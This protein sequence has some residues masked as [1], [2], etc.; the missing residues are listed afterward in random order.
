LTALLELRGEVL[1]PP[2][3]RSLA[4]LSAR[5]SHPVLLSTALARLDLPQLQVAEALAALGAGAGRAALYRMV[6]AGG[7]GER[8]AVDE[9]LAVLG[10][11]AMMV[12][13]ECRLDPGLEAGWPEPLDLGVHLADVLA[14]LTVDDLRAALSLW[15][16]GGLA[17]LGKAALV[18][19][20]GRPLGD[21]DR[22]RA[23]VAAAP[24]PLPEA[25]VDAA[26]GR[27]RFSHWTSFRPGHLRYRSS[28]LTPTEW[29]MARLLLVPS[30]YDGELQLPA[31][32]ALALR[33]PN[34]HAP[35]T[36]DPPAIRR[37][38]VDPAAVQRSA[39]A[40]GGDAVR[41]A[42]DVLRLVARQPP[43]LLKN[44]RLGARE[45]R[46]LGKELDTSP[47]RVRFV[48]A[49][50]HHRGLI[51]H[52]RGKLVTTAAAGAWLD[53]EPGA[54]LAALVA[55]WME[56]PDIPLDVDELAWDPVDL[57]RAVEARRAVL[58]VLDENPDLTPSQREDVVAAAYWRRP[59]PMGR[60][61]RGNVAP[62]VDDEGAE[63]VTDSDR[64]VRAL[65]AEAEILG[66]TGGGA[67][68]PAGRAAARGQDVRAAI[69][70]ALGRAQEHAVLQADLTA[71]V[72]GQPSAPLA[73]L[74]DLMADRESRSTANVWRFSPTSIRRALDTGR[75]ADDLIAD[76]VVA[77]RDEIPQALR[78]LVSDTG[79]QHGRLQVGG[80]GSYVV[81]EDAALLAEVVAD[82]RLRRLDLRLL[83][84]TVLVSPVPLDELMRGLRAAGHGAVALRPDGTPVIA[85]AG[86]GGSTPTAER[87]RSRPAAGIGLTGPPS[88]PRP[89]AV[90]TA[91]LAAGDTGKRLLD[92]G[93]TVIDIDSLREYAD[94]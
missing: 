70:S 78:Y 25:L 10:T 53:A 2:A 68:S 56:L 3:P 79:R 85:R 42:G 75:T 11:H 40:A 24:A 8:R 86:E 6:G 26:F 43:A 67:L 23:V 33:G 9:A 72:L 39:A 94:G 30:P 73:A 1:G 38:R 89:A 91:L 83:A 13:G 63:P 5:L 12:P 54:A 34:W 82:R 88:S 59:I 66:V 48:V 21:P 4:E 71:T 60:G 28:A 74:L 41:L 47:E 77:G 31:E 14:S 52:E 44:G 29:A 20:L 17:K 16:V 32:I 50:G 57:P 81:G 62:D 15:G 55:T 27:H 90:A 61:L 87:P 46:R 49:L 18:A 37:T 19:A 76:L 84:P 36:P 69:G 7:P 92:V 65:L 45:L 51:D 58:A 80:A 35:F 93:Q 22:V 64:T